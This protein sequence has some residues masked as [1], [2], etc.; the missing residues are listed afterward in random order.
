L[1]FGDSRNFIWKW[2]YIGNLAMKKILIIFS[3]FFILTSAGRAQLWKLK[4]YEL[5]AGIGTTQ[6]YGDI[7]GFTQG[8]NI[9]GIKD[10]TFHNTS[11]NFS[12]NFGYKLRE[13]V[14]VRFNL[15]L[16]Y[17]HSADIVGSNDQRGFESKTL[18]FEPSLIG[19]YYFVKSKRENNYTFL[20]GNRTPFQAI[21]SLLNCYAF[22]G[23]GG[24][25]YNVSPNNKLEP[26]ATK[27]NG[28]TPVVPVGIGVKMIYSASLSFGI[29]MGAR[30]AFSDNV[31]GYTSVYSK[32]N[33][34][35]HLLNLSV[36]YKINTGSNGL[37]LF[38]KRSF[39]F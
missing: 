7:G 23:I 4:R 11:F 33:D 14:S 29:E 39:G 18:F 24:L 19:E 8:K 3:I 1:L 2:G 31:D 34:R 25:S 27:L 16:G 21:I 9:L 32:S 5:S 15:A 12:A 28:F 10:F 17:F 30:F 6:F 37:P 13:D 38:R 36:I 35:Y 26:L 20:K 22:T